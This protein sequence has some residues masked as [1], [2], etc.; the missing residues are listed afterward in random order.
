MTDPHQLAAALDF[1][2]TPPA[3]RMALSPVAYQ[4]RRFMLEDT[5]AALAFFTSQYQPAPTPAHRAALGVFDLAA[6]VWREYLPTFAASFEPDTAALSLHAWASLRADTLT[7]LPSSATV[8]AWWAVRTVAAMTAG[9]GF[10][11]GEPE[12]LLSAVLAALEAGTGH[13]LN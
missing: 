4:R 12:D 2:D 9:P 5:G 3:P 7:A 6:A 13:A 11:D 8:A 10:A 1:L